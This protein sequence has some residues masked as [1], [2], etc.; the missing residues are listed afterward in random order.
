MKRNFVNGLFKMKKKTNKHTKQLLSESASKTMAV[1]FTE[2]AIVTFICSFFL[3]S[4]QES[5]KSGHCS[6]GLNSIHLS[7]C[8]DSI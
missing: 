8:Q 2:G 5:N 3:F 6:F 4:F 1:Y 7:T